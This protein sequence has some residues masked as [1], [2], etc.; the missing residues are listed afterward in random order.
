MANKVDWNEFRRETASRL[1]A[2]YVGGFG[3]STEEKYRPLQVATCIAYADELTKQL[4]E[5]EE[6]EEKEG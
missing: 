5:K 1:L 2:T 6:Q 4:K 3:T